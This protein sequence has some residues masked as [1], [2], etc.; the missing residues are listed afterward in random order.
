MLGGASC[1]GKVIHE[2][3]GHLWGER[4]LGGERTSMGEKALE[5]RDRVAA[6]LR[7]PIFALGVRPHYDISRAAR[8]AGV[9]ELVDALDLGSSDA[10]RGGSN[11]SAR[12]T[13]QVD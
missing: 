12:T 6:W 2:G 10:S 11:P 3:K 8:S 4:Q 1:G 13:R 5:R 7:I 9:A